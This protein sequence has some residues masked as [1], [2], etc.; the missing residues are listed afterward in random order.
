MASGHE[1]PEGDGCPICF[2]LIEL[3]VDAHSK[4]N[5]CC[6]KRVCDGCI[7]AARQRGINDICPFCRTPLPADDA[8]ELAMVQKRV[9]K[10]DAEAIFNAT[11]ITKV[12]LGWQ[13][14]SLERSNC[15]RRLQSLDYWMHRAVS[16]TRIIM[17]MVSKKTNQGAFTT[18][19]R[20]RC[21]GT[22]SAGTILAFLNSI[23]RTANFPCSTS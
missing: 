6:M 3:P 18:G 7:L 22:W 1:R 10:G 4:M 5:A 2:L 16:V 11:F 14:M 9:D 8:S 23:I 15:G 13:R 17:A 21:K 19:N 20:P 12:N